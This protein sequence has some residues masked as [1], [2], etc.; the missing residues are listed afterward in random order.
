M[1]RFHRAI[2]MITIVASATFLLCIML[3]KVDERRRDV[4][5]MRLMGIS[6]ATVV[7]S[8]MLES[9]FVALLGSAFGVVLGF[10]VVGVRQRALPGRVSYAAQVRDR[11]AKHGGVLGA[12]VARPRDRSGGAGRAAACA[13]SAARRCS[14]ADALSPR[15]AARFGATRVG[16]LLAMLGVAVSAAMLLDMVMLATGMRESFASLLGRNGFT[17]S[18][19]TTRHAAVRHRGNDRQAA[20]RWRRCVRSPGVTA[21]APVLGTTISRVRQWSR[22]DRVRA[23]GS[24][25]RCRATTSCSTGAEPDRG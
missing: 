10:A 13:H 15:C 20:R 4:A 25:R 11:H 14:A 2:G 7:R 3:L 24:I 5:A 22:R 16:P 9:S 23:R 18:C 6:R 1:S 21:V 8:V 17:D 19:L 12:A